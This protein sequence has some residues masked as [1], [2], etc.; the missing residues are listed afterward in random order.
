MMH[1]RG[2]SVSVLGLFGACG[3]AG[4]TQAQVSVDEFLD[5]VAIGG[6]WVLNPVLGNG[7]TR[8]DVFTNTSGDTRVTLTGVQFTI[9]N[10]E[11]LGFTDIFGLPETT[12]N[13]F[14][15]VAAA[16][17]LHPGASVGANW[18]EDSDV[19]P[20]AWQP[21]TIE[22]PLSLPTLDPGES[23]T[24]E[25]TIRNTIAGVQFGDNRDFGEFIIVFEV[26]GTT[27]TVSEFEWAAPADG[28]WQ[29]AANWSP[30]SVPGLGDDATLGMTG[31]YTVTLDANARVTMLDMPNPDAI[32]A[33][34]AG[35]QLRTSG[36]TGAG[37]V[38]VNSDRGSETSF[39][40]VERDTVF[41]ANALLNAEPS[42]PDENWQTFA[43]IL[44]SGSVGSFAELGP[45]SRVTG[46]GALD[47]DIRAAGTIAPGTAA[48]PIGSIRFTGGVVTFRELAP[49]TRFEFD[50]AGTQGSS[51]NT[52]FRPAEHDQI[53]LT[54]SSPTRIILLDGTVAVTLA[55][56]YTPAFGDEWSL[57]ES[58]ADQLFGSFDAVETPTPPPGLVYRTELREGVREQF[59]LSLACLADVNEDGTADSGDFFAWV[60]AFSTQSTGCDQNG[61]G[62]CDSGDF[63]AWVANFSLGCG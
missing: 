33:V 62:A 41:N 37:T 46:N 10:P 25:T 1:A 48:D 38:V 8:N 24:L 27:E 51:P 16:Q 53:F 21:V 40:R 47:G 58:S 56:G 52:Q 14:D 30:A 50:L 18:W 3:L 59:V 15:V 57:I 13:V 12:T 35:R 55:E 20:L 63:F 19:D 45:A 26:F 5:R 17:A 6:E 2:H 32:I 44:Q 49:T 36:T 11:D 31:P 39:L 29:D 28:S 34:P 9:Y 60:N 42:N 43:R 61:D 4:F 22:A 7:R 23:F 54:G